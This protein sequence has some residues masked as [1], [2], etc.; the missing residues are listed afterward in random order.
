MWDFNELAREMPELTA[1]AK[2]LAEERL[3]RA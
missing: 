3:Q 2:V 1:H